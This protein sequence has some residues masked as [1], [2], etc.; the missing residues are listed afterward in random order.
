MR[1]DISK[2]SAPTMPNLGKVTK[3]IKILLSQAPKDVHE[4]FVLRFS[5]SICE[6]FLDTKNQP[7]SLNCKELNTK[8]PVWHVKSA[9]LTRDVGKLD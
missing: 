7:Q 5:P 4:P 8:W 9:N 3:C 2:A 6:H 1:Y